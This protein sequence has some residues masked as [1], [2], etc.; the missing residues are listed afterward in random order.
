[1]MIC[2]YCVAEWGKKCQ[3]RCPYLSDMTFLLRRWW[4]GWGALPAHTP[5]PVTILLY[6]AKE[7]KGINNL[8]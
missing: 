2:V 3:W 4:V 1:M 6:S 8:N 5:L 7:R